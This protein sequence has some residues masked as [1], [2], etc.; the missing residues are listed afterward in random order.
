MG[1]MS[2]A[3][4]EEEDKSIIYGYSRSFATILYRVRHKNRINC[5]IPQAATCDIQLS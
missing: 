2:T 5:G 4:A 1:D 3:K